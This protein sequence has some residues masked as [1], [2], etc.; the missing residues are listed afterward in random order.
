[1][2]SLA[3]HFYLTVH[4]LPMTSK[5]QYLD[6]KCEAIL[7]RDHI[8]VLTLTSNDEDLKDFLRGVAVAR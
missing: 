1:M 2:D 6:D 5:L 7:L 3:F 4:T 8:T